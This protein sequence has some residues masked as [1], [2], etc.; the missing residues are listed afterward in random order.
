M[1]DTLPEVV[2]TSALMKLFGCN[3]RTITDLAQRGILVRT[4][5]GK[6]DLA[7][8]TQ[9]YL[10]HLRDQAAG[11]KSGAEEIDA[12]LEGRAPEAR[13]APRRRIGAQA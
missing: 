12:V 6:Y 10:A 7:A 11:R 4:D 3:R 2:S 5:R 13:A 8:S 9:R 1:S